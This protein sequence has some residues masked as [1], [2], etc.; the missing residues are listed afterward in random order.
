IYGSETKG[1]GRYVC[2]PR[3]YKMLDHEYELM[4][5][6]LRELRPEQNFFAFADTVAAI[7]FQKTIKGDGWLGLRFQLHPEQETNDA[8]LHVRLL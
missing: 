7:N 3:L 5:G 4:E 2:E 1:K 6:R 8:I